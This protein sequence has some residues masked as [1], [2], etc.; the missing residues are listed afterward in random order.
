MK[1]LIIYGSSGSST[2]KTME[3]VNTLKEQLGADFIDVSNCKIS[4]FDYAHNN[5]GDD[6]HGIAQQMVSAECIIFA[7]PVYWYAMS[8][9]LKVFFDRLSDLITIRKPLGRQ[10]EGKVMTF[11]ATGHDDLLPEGFYVPFKRTAEYFNM[12]YTEGMY[13]CTNSKVFNQS[14]ANEKMIQFAEGF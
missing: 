3:V 7:T 10:L 8:A 1:Y 9:Q 6:F 4:F 12:S 13:I 11:V 2:G 5:K 14:E